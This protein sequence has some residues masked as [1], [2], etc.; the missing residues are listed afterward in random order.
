VPHWDTCKPAAGEKPGFETSWLNAVY[1]LQEKTR[2]CF[3]EAV[4][5]S[6]C[7]SKS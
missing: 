4:F 3:V 6:L 5:I 2:K 7:A 1:K